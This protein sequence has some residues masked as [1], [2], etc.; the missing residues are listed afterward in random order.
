MTSRYMD[1]RAK[2]RRR[3]R[4]HHARIYVL[5]MMR[6]VYT[7]LHESSQN[8]PAGMPSMVLAGGLDEDG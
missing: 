8:G 3:E 7:M 6:A 4:D 2:E 5:A 1:D